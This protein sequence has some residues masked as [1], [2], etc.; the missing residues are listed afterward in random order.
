[1]C[2]FVVRHC[3][4]GSSRI[5]GIDFY[6]YYGPVSHAYL[7]RINISKVTIH[8]I[9]DSILDASNA[10]QNKKFQFMKLFCVSTPPCYLIW[11]ENTTLTI[12]SIVIVV[13][14]FVQFINGIKGT[15]TEVIEVNRLLYEL[16]TVLKYNKSTINYSI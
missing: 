7:F 15:K 4:N 2:I 14:F 8:W 16:V 10:F 13:H 6:L 1:M 11:S 9:T 12:L 3:N 5:Q